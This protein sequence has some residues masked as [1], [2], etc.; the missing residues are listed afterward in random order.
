MP[1]LSP[2]H[3]QSVARCYSTPCCRG[4]YWRRIPLAL[5]TRRQQ[6][7]PPEIS[8]SGETSCMK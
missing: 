1:P 8:A 5:Q 7:Q 3:S 6:L 4:E 2:L